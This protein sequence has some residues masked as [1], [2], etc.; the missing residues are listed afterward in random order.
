MWM[1][2]LHLHVNQKSDYD[3][4]DIQTLLKSCSHIEDVHFPFCAHLINIFSF[5]MGVEFRHFFHPKCVWGVW[6]V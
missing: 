1:M 5:L 4:D 6:F 3:D 2:P